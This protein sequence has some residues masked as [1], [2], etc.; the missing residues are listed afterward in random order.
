MS[1]RLDPRFRNRLRRAVGRRL[2]A[3]VALLL[4]VILTGHLGGLW[5]PLDLAS[6]FQVQYLVAAVVLLLIAA[7][8]GLWRSA[9]AAVLCVVLAAPRVAPWYLP[10]GG[11]GAPADGPALRVMLCNVLRAN[12]EHRQLLV[13]VQQQ[14]PDV[15]VLLEVNDRWLA[16]TAAVRDHLPHTI[17]DPREDDFGIAVFSRYPIERPQITTLGSAGVRSI[18]CELRLPEAEATLVATHPLPPVSPRRTRLRDE[19][20]RAV[21]DRFAGID[22]PAILVGDFNASMWSAPYRALAHQTDLVNARRGH[23]V[24]PSWPAFLPEFMRIP[25]DHCLHSREITVTGC[26]AGEPIG[27]DHLPLTIDLLLPPRSTAQRS[28]P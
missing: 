13:L 23:G 22:G 17:S 2:G 27:S 20:L 12:H 10:I 28:A 3:L 21:A 11:E 24:L 1:R 7:G 19:Q 18:V 14:Q 6:H 15:L 25:I 9:L 5:S 16:A 26:A 8:L 4:A